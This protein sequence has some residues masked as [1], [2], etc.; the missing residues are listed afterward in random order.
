MSDAPNTGTDTLEINRIIAAPRARVWAA[1]TEPELVKRW[2]GPKDYTSPDCRIDLRIGGKYLFAMRA[3][4]EWGGGDSYTSGEYL[5]IEPI[6]RLEFTENIA[7]SDGVPLPAG[8]PG[9]PPDFPQN[10]RTMVVFTEIA[11]LTRVR[12]TS[13]GW[14]AGTMFVFAFAG[15]HQSLDKLEASLG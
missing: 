15:M 7:D 13:S 10:L 6:D 9:L 12:I 8:H 11:G 14:T 2:W 1:W 3:P 4:E 5:R